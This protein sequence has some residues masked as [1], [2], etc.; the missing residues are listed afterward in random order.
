VVDTGR[1][2]AGRELLASLPARLVEPGENLGFAAGVNRGAETVDGEVLVAANPDVEPLPGCLA[3]LAAALGRG[4][5]AA[6]PRLWWDR[7]RRLRLPPADRHDGTS[8]LL[9]RLA[10]PGGAWARRARRRWRRHAR[11]HWLAGEPL[12]SF[13]LSGALLAIDR[14]AWRRL[15]PFDE[16]YRL[17]FEETDWLARARRAG[18]AAVYEPR[19]EAVHLYN[20]SAAG[21][22]LAAGWFAASARRFAR[23]H[24]PAWRVALLTAAERWAGGR[25]P[26]WPP[27]LPPGP[28]V[29]DLGSLVA[30]SGAGAATEPGER[31]AAGDGRALATVAPGGEDQELWV[32]VSPNPSGLPAAGE[33]LPPG[34][35]SEESRWR[36][37]DEVWRDLTPGRWCLAVVDGRG[38][39]LRR[40]SFVRPE[41]Q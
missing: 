31:R 29:L 17:Y 10:A 21:E 20:R 8:E 4:A 12:A 32:E 6:G 18:L 34:A 5:A 15:G 2:A 25:P 23:R 27:A 7:Q 26:R 39:E 3:A 28:P 16:G 22:P 24:H 14:G 19:A 41:G 9:A 30:A 33:R 38:R 35:V 40:R 36:F 13:A 37:P 11:R 1:A